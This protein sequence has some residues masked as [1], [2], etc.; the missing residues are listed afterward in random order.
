MGSEFRGFQW[1]GDLWKDNDEG[2]SGGL[3]SLSAHSLALLPSGDRI[4]DTSFCLPYLPVA[5]P[6][7]TI[8]SHLKT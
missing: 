6:P 3:G 4:Q 5:S 7:S 8:H 1:E 2:S